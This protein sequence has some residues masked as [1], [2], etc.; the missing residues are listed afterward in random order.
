MEQ[1]DFVH[2]G[3]LVLEQGT[4]GDCAYKI[5]S[6]KVDICIYNEAGEE[7]LLAQVGPG[8][9]IGEMA[10]IL[11]GR[12]CASA[13]ANGD[14]VLSR[15][16]AQELHKSVK[17]SASVREYVMRLIAKRMIRNIS[18]FDGLT[19]KE[20][21]NLP[22]GEGPVLYSKKDLLFQEGDLIEYL[23]LL[24]SGHIQH[25]NTTDDGEE[26]TVELHKPGDVFCKSAVC[27][28][29]KFYH[30]SARAIDDV[31]VIK[32][33]IREFKAIMLKH[34]TVAEKLL[35]FLAERNMLKQREMQQRAT[36]TAPQ[37]LAAFLR[38]LCAS[39][40]F[41]PK[42]FTLPYRKSLIA[43]RLGMETETLSRAWPKLEEYGIIAN[44]SRI[45]IQDKS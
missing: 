14:V 18:L 43:A 19:Q 42:G 10:V 45:T 29:D 6:G 34:P 24:C 12:R 35:A 25:F 8:E 21:E 11:G 32:L 39:H 37:I 28:Q 44:G 9:L 27:M 31:H 30:T 13:R 2:N 20:K 7:V 26:I 23:Y 36:M 4:L 41:D 40:G 3:T 38:E 17:K 16:T 5:E 1:R 22:E 33:P 15:I